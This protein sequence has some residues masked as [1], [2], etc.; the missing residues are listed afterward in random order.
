MEELKFNNNIDLYPIHEEPLNI[1]KYLFETL[2]SQ[3]NGANLYALYSLY[4]STAKWQRTEYPKAI[5]VY[6]SKKLNWGKN[7]VEK[8]KAEL[9]K[10][11]LIE[12]ITKT[13]NGRIS[14]HYVK[15]NFGNTTSPIFKEVINSGGIYSNKNIYTLTRDTPFLE[16]DLSIKNNNTSHEKTTIYTSLAKYLGIIIQTKKNIKIQ[17]SKIKAWSLE[18][19]KLVEIDSVNVKRIKVGLKWYEINIG[20]QFV[21]VIESGKSLR[22]KFIKLEDAIKRGQEPK[23]DNHPMKRAP[24]GIGYWWDEKSGGYYNKAGEVWNY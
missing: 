19:Q 14:G 18:I 17:P 2:T 21:P 23:K 7:K 5:N 10:L 13:L 24:D 4:Y 11:G 3:P 8:Y 16:Q 9:I 22:E 6:V 1:S 20:L 12:N 15:V